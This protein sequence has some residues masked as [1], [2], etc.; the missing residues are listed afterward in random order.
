MKQGEKLKTY[1]GKA[2]PLHGNDIDTD[3]IIP[4]RFMR[5]VTFRGLGKYAM[6]D[7]R[8]SNDGKEKE[9]IFNKGEYNKNTILLVNKNFGCGSSREH[10]PWALYDF[11]IRLII[12]ESF[13]EIFA[14]NCNSLGIPAIIVNQ[15][16]IRTLM[17]AVESDP[18]LELQVDLEELTIQYGSNSMN[19]T[20]PETYRQAMLEGEWDTTSILLQNTEKIN[21]TA[22]DLPY[23]NW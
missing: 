16:Q 20:M 13:A 23:L 15:D 22:N 18:G 21:N 17:N 2:I 5:C 6:Y 10:A 7:E 12:G 8:F 4:A 3:R 1:K 9:H 14:G 11:G 19:F